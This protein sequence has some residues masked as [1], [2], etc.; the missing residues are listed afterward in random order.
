M[1]GMFCHLISEKLTGQRSDVRRTWIV[2]KYRP[3]RNILK[4]YKTNMEIKGKKRKE[5]AKITGGVRKKFEKN[6]TK[7]GI[8]KLHFVLSRSQWPRAM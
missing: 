4:F 5:N 3:R 1:W 2:I 6:N 8:Q 7:S